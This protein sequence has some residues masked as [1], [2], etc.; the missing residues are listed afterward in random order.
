MYMEIRAKI[1]EEDIRLITDRKDYN[2][3]NMEQ[4]EY[5]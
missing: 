2:I 3:E 1:T 4:T 5:L